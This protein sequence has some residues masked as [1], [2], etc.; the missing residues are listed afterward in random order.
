MRWTASIWRIADVMAPPSV[1]LY[2]VHGTSH[3]SH[4]PRSAAADC[5]AQLPRL[6]ARWL[7][8]TG[9]PPEMCG[10]W[11]RPWMEVDPPRVELPSAGGISSRRPR[12]IWLVY[13]IYLA[14]QP[15]RL[16]FPCSVLFFSRP[17]SEGWPHHGRT[18]SIYPCPL[19]FWLT[20]PRRVLSTSL[21]CP[22]RPCVAL[23]LISRIS[24]WLTY[25]ADSNWEE[26]IARLTSHNLIIVGPASRLRLVRYDLQTDKHRKIA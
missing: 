10:L 11:T 1:A 21:C 15:W 9:R 16:N 5:V 4:P 2:M 8:A 18:F 22:S 13:C 6:S 23:P 3:P 26:L 20:L 7:P 19:S 17:R 12:G 14:I 24:I 25:P